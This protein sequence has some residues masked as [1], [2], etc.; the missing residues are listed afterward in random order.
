MGK[1]IK[2]LVIKIKQNFGTCLG[3]KKRCHAAAMLSCGAW[4]T[5]PLPYLLQEHRCRGFLHSFCQYR[6]MLL[7]DR[8][9]YE[10]ITLPD[11]TCDLLITSP[12]S[13]SPRPPIQRKNGQ[14]ND[15]I[16]HKHTM[17]AECDTVLPILS[18]VCLSNECV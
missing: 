15:F 13:S 2:L 16:T 10:Q 14:I 12:T 7:H 6:F 3:T 18:D 8:G 9:V 4:L 17:H 5:L 1:I 11:E